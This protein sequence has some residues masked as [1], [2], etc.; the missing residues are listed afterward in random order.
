MM[1]DLIEEDKKI[2]EFSGISFKGDRAGDFFQQ[3]SQIE[4]LKSLH[5]GLEILDIETALREFPEL[6]EYY[7]KAL[8]AAGKD[9]DRDTRGGYFIRVRKNVKIDSPIQACLFLKAQGFKQKVHNLIILEEGAEA[10]LITGCS[11]SKSASE[12]IH[13]GISEFFIGRNAKLNFTMI[14]SW[15]ED[16]FVRPITA[17]VVD[18]NGIFTSNYVCLR[19]VKDVYMHPT[20]ILNGRN[21][22]AFFS[23]LILCHPESKF[24][25]GSNSI[26]MARDAHTEIN[27]RVASLGG[28]VISRGNITALSSKSRG[29]L[30]CNGLLLSDEGS[31]KAIPELE[32]KFRDVELSHEAAI[33]RIK[34]EEIEYLQ[35]RGFDEK[36]AREF[37]VK[38]FMDVN[39]LKVPDFLKE[40]INDAKGNIFSRQQ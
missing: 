30:E 5:P 4:L 29:H 33:G 36:S 2:I 18:D 37:I 31:I 9:F 13:V 25:I 23:S 26:M 14:H 28:E 6:K 3:N 8:S 27:T 32:T 20:A 1:P 15:N 35:S 22:G 11:A 21:A 10:T 24:D 17:A 40:Q 38:G 12:S 34:K 39:V 7:C 19:S 16:T